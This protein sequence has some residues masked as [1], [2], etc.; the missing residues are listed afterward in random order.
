MYICA[1]LECL[2]AAEARIRCQ[3]L[4][5]AKKKKLK[6]KK[7]SILSGV[8]QTQRDKYGMFHLYVGVAVNSLI[9]RLQYL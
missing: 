1:P 4:S 9:R 2:A 7:K 6:K 5:G 8:T 3:I